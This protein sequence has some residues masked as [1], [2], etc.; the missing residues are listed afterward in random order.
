MPHRMLRSAAAVLLTGAP[1]VAAAPAQAA[2]QHAFPCAVGVQ[3]VS[4][5][6]TSRVS[7]GITCA[8]TRTVGVSITANGTE[9]LSLQQTVQAGVQQSV[10]LTVPRVEQVCA[11]VQTDG[12]ST[13]ICTP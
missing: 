1:L 9:L 3:K 2:A 12:E 6:L 10:T 7:V 13:T 11:T 4:D 8:A 5:T